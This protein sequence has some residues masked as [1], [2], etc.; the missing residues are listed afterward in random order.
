MLPRIVRVQTQLEEEEEEL[1]RNQMVGRNER[2]KPD[3]QNLE[4]LKRKMHFDEHSCQYSNCLDTPAIMLSQS[5]WPLPS[6]STWDCKCA[7]AEAADFMN[8]DSSSCTQTEAKKSKTSQYSRRRGSHQ[9][10][11]PASD[12]VIF[13]SPAIAD[14]L[15]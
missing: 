12:I 9:N 2:P 3:F 6:S 5:S 8:S 11:R 10:F 13:R 15:S 1:E 4:T 7:N 14:V